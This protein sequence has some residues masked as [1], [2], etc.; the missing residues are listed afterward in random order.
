MS[1]IKIASI[2]SP[3]SHDVCSCTG[4]V[5]TNH[6]WVHDDIPLD[7]ACIVVM[8]Y[9]IEQ[10]VF[11]SDFRN[12]LRSKNRKIF[13]WLGESYGISKRYHDLLLG[14]NDAV[15]EVR[16]ML[17]G[18]FTHHRGLISKYSDVFSYVPNY[19]NITWVKNRGL[20]KKTK[21]VSIV[22]SGKAFLPGHIVRNDMVSR[23]HHRF[24]HFDLYGR[25]IRP[26]SFK[27]DVLN[28]YMFSV[29][30]ENESYSTYITEK[31]M[32]C[33]ATGTVPIYYGS[34][35]VGDLFDLRGMIILDYE[36]IHNGY[37]ED[38]ESIDIHLYEKMKPFVEEN[39][40]RAQN[41]VMADDVLYEKVIKKI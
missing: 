39:Y 6:E 8:E 3:F 41:I 10:L 30:I 33:F 5:P 13:V 15:R 14:N 24:P 9:A 2:G 16:E 29:V 23:I 22:N 37:F 38:I 35:D 28:D 26:F 1:K 11:R 18:I 4:N 25:G 19:A 21:F 34:P 40:H 7:C 17:S 31:L 27:E 20:H 32:D 36:K 12:F